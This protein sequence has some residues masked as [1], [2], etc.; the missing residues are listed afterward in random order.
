MGKEVG[1]SKMEG[2]MKKQKLKLRIKIY[3]TYTY[4]AGEIYN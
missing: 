3:K 4:L 2:K 1:N